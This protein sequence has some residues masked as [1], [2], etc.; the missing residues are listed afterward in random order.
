MESNATCSKQDLQP[1]GLNTCAVKRNREMSSHENDS[2]QLTRQTGLIEPQ[3][4]AGI[5]KISIKT[6]HK[7]VR[8][9]KLSCVQVTAR[10]RRFCPAFVRRSDS[11]SVRW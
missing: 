8:E 2:S 3:K 4:V 5:L 10:E 1:F 6:V 7:L 11:R 9:G